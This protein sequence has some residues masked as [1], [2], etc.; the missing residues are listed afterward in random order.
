MYSYRIC[1]MIRRPPVSK[2]T[3][4]LYPYTTRCRSRVLDA[5]IRLAALA[6]RAPVEADDRGVAEIGIDA[7]E[8][9]RVRHGD[10]AVVGPG[11]G[12]G[13]HHLLLQIG[14]AHV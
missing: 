1:F 3:D 8:A 14:R 2:R 12:L 13:H 10:V 4:T 6:Q 5:V 7:V 9:R 11:H